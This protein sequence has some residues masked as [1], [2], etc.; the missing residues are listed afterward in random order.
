MS[1]VS[2]PGP[3]PKRQLRIH[4]KE[5]PISSTG[6]GSPIQSSIYKSYDFPL[7]FMNFSPCTDTIQMGDKI[8]IVG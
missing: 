7:L 8:V 5:L 2:Y 3:E 4:R 1:F 6:P